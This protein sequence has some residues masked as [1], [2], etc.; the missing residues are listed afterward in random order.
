M[1]PDEKFEKMSEDFKWG[2]EMGYLEALS[3]ILEKEESV[4]LMADDEKSKTPFQIQTFVIDSKHIR[5][6]ISDRVRDQ[7]MDS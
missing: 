6:L 5:M 3:D 2:R 1:I 7:E 4:M